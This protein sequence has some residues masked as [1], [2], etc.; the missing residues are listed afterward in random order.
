M[1]R[2]TLSSLGPKVIAS[3]M[4]AD[5]VNHLYVPAAASAASV[6]PGVAASRSQAKARMREGWSG[7]RVEHVESSGVSDSPQ[8]GDEVSIRAFV[9]LGDLAPSDVSVQLVHG[10]VTPEDTLVDTVAQDLTHVEAYEA[11]RHCFEGVVKLRRTGP[12]GYTVRVLPAGLGLAN[13]AELGL[14]AN[15]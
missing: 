2:H 3:R 12:F 4:V 7:V 14:V 13:P 11:G 15:A 9:T 10:R 6:T 8:V 1:V 5:Y